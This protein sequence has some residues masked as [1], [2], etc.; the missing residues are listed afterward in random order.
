VLLLL[1]VS[2]FVR[3]QIIGQLDEIR[4]G[5]SK[6]AASNSHCVLK[7]QSAGFGLSLQKSGYKDRRGN[8][9]DEEGVIIC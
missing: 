4:T 9:R 2:I 3:V 5:H 6:N 7:R 1:I 8:T